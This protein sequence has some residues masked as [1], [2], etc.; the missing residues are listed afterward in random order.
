MNADLPQYRDDTASFI[1]T[2]RLA[3][4]QVFEPRACELFLDI[5]DA[6]QAAQFAQMSPMFEREHSAV[7]Q[8]RGPSTSG[9][10][11]KEHIVIRLPFNVGCLERGLMQSILGSDPKRELFGL[12]RIREGITP[13]SVLVE[14]AGV[15]LR[16]G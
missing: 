1:E 8:Y 10:P 7:I 13:V 6:A 5:D 12:R 11:G 16:H 15:D 14:A 4:L 3:G 9:K 2:A